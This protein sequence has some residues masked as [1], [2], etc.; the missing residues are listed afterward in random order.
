MY[1]ET[2]TFTLFLMTACGGDGPSDP[3][4]PP[5]PPPPS[6]VWQVT[7]TWQAVLE[8]GNDSGARCEGSGSLSIAQ[9]GQSF[10]GELQY[11][12]GSMCSNGSGFEQPLQAAF[13]TEGR[14]TDGAATFKLGAPPNA[15]EVNVSLEGEVSSASK[16]AKKMSGSMTCDLSLNGIPHAVAGTITAER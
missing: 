3:V 13:V 12:S 4:A 5:P 14:V 1:R 7:G 11:A 10:T 9:A 2:V 6:D 8:G 16:M 15:C